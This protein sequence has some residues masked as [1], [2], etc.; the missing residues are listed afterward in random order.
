MRLKSVLAVMLVLAIVGG[1]SGCKGKKAKGAGASSADLKAFGSPKDL[2]VGEDVYMHQS[3]DM[4]G[5]YLLYSIRRDPKEG[6][7]FNHGMELYSYNMEL[8]IKLPLGKLGRSDTFGFITLG[9][10][11]MIAVAKTVDTDDNGD[12]DERDGNALYVMAPDGLDD[13]PVSPVRKHVTGYWGDPRGELVIFSTADHWEGKVV[14]PP[15]EG[16]KEKEPDWSGVAYTWSFE[17]K[18]TNELGRCLAF[19]GVSPDGEQFACLPP[20]GVGDKS[21]EVLIIPRDGT[22]NSKATLPTTKDAQVTP[23]GGGR[24]AY[25]RIE[26]SS[27]GERRTLWIHGADGKDVRVTS[28][29]VDTDILRPLADGGM[30]FLSRAEYTVDDKSMLRAISGDGAKVKDLLTIKG[31]DLLQMPI[32]TGDGKMFSYAVFPIDSFEANPKGVLW[33]ASAKEKAKWR[34]AKEVAEEKIAGLGETIVEA[35]QKALDDGSPVKEDAISVDVPG[36]RAVLPMAIKEEVTDASLMEAAKSVRSAVMPVLAKEGYSA[37]LPLDGHKDA[38][39]VMRWHPEFGRHLTYF[40]AYGNWV[41]VRDEYDIVVEDLVYKKLPGCRDPRLVQLHCNGWIAAVKDLKTESLDLVCRADPLDP[42]MKVREGREAVSG[43]APGGEAISFDVI[44]DKV[45]PRRSHRSTFELQIFKGSQQTPFYD[46]SWAE[47]T[48]AWIEVLRGIPGSEVVPTTKLH[49]F[50]MGDETFLPLAKWFPSTVV[51]QEQH[52]DT[53]IFIDEEGTPAM[54]DKEAWDALATA[55]M[56]SFTPFLEE[57]DLDNLEKVR[58]SLYKGQLLMTEMWHK[59]PEEI[60]IEGCDLGNGDACY[61]LGLIMMEK[62]Q[63]MAADYAFYDGCDMGSELACEVISGAGASTGGGGAAKPAAEP[64]EE[65]PALKKKSALPPGATKEPG[66]APSL[67]KSEIQ[68][69]IRENLPEVKYCFQK[70]AAGSGQMAVTVKI[71]IDGKGQVEGVAVKHSNVTQS[72]E[73]CV[74][75]AV[76]RITFPEPP[77]G[78]PL[79]LSYPFTYVP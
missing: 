23:L 39:A 70:E 22:G 59:T 75:Q 13:E 72:I 79:K 5:K 57:H 53:H 32:L 63:K 60:A 62:G 73:T 71:S 29:S 10:K 6:W 78:Q 48:T 24:L 58:V 1:C 64:E 55:L 44:A 4:E 77:D 15:K 33:V 45:D 43:V 65:E 47:A 19:Y 50:A 25:T 56:D 66:K 35:L 38:V 34:P 30:L 17:T 26:S 46:A 37:V 67:K 51:R 52:L 9:E 76:R 12:V 11:V 18:A 36:K 16:E 28:T 69:A 40:V 42:G 74:L 20:D 3:L 61:Q 49:Y 68:A 54:E 31:S 14:P 21:I 2:G 41:P 27:T 7:G 8:N